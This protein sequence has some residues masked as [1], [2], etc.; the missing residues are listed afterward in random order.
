MFICARG[1]LSL[2][3][4]VNFVPFVGFV[5]KLIYREI[6]FVVALVPVNFSSNKSSWGDVRVGVKTQLVIVFMSESR[7]SQSKHKRLLVSL[8]DETMMR[9]LN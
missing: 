1:R 4:R 9:D 2:L 8:D 6:F 5:W 7:G 3:F